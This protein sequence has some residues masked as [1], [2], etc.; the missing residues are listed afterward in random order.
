MD[1]IQKPSD[2]ERYTPS[3]EPYKTA[4]HILIYFILK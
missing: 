1:T 4:L 2:S 3:W